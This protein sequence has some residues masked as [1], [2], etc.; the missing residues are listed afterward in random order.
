M[1]KTGSRVNSMGVLS[2]PG[3]VETGWAVLS[4]VDSDFRKKNFSA[5]ITRTCTVSAFRNGVVAGR[6]YKTFM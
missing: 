2:V 6:S 4:K 3:G 5:S 1:W